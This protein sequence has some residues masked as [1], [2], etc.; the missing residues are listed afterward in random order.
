MDIREDLAKRVGEGAAWRDTADT[1]S[2]ENERSAYA[3]RELAA[4][5]MT[6]APADSRLQAIADI[7]LRKDTF[8]G[9]GDEIDQ[10]IAGYGGNRHLQS[11]PDT[12]M[13]NLVGIVDRKAQ[14]ARLNRKRGGNG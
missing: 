5:V 3:L 12:F 9:G 1:D 11:H 13:R 4:H 2:E 8:P 7:D 10:L 6:M 14:V